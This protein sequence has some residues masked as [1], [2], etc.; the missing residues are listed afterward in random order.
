MFRKVSFLAIVASMFFACKVQAEVEDVYSNWVGGEWGFWSHPSNWDPQIVPDNNPSQTFIVTI[1]SNRIGVGDVIIVLQPDHTIDQL[2]V[3]GEVKL[4]GRRWE[5]EPYLRIL[6]PYNRITNHGELEIEE[7][8]IL[9]DV[10]NS[11]GAY[12]GGSFHIEE[13]CIE[14]SGTIFLKPNDEIWVECEFENSGVIEIYDGT[15]SSN[16]GFENQST[17]LI[18]GFGVLYSQQT[19]RNKGQIIAF[20]G[21]LIIGS[22]GHVINEGL[23]GNHAMSSLHIKPAP[24][25]NNNGTIEVN[26]GG[27]VA[28]DCNLVNESATSIK[29]LG[30][31]L[32]ATTITQTAGANFA[33]FGGITGDVVIEPDGLIELTGPTNIVGDV[34]I[35]PDATLAISD[36]TTLITGHTSCNGTIHMK[37]GWIIPQGGLSG[38]CNIIWEPGIYSNVADFNLDG[39]V[40]F[41]DFALFTDTWLWQSSWY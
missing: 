39:Q 10:L 41:T 12:L 9:G 26:A 1:D 13:G 3:Y 8:D 15:F 14:N 34:T 35:S 29:L 7:V 33:G 40:N 2:N 32:V 17:G 21:S 5:R 11:S 6:K 31:T 36:G 23:L 24:D 4:E 30:G 20:G 19:V 25:V 38:A 27:G 28:F 18:R 16:Q 37:G 22:E